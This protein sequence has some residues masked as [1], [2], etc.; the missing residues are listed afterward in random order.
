MSGRRVTLPTMM[1]L[2]DWADQTML[3]L[4]YYGILGHLD[5][6]SKWQ[7]WAMQ[8]L[9]N[10]SLGRNLPNPYQFDDWREWAERMC[11]SLA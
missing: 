2:S 4:D 7:D 1:T 3:D 5:D 11:G 8:F 6:E 9:N 10:T